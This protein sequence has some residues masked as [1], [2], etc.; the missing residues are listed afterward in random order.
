[1]QAIAM[2]VQH[3]PYLKM[4]LTERVN[5]RR[6]RRQRMWVTPPIVV[7]KPAPVYYV[8][9]RPAK[10]IVYRMWFEDLIL[11]AEQS[12]HKPILRIEHVQ[13][14]CARF[15]GITREDILNICRKKHFV[16]PRQVA[17]Y[18]AKKITL[19]SFPEIGRRFGGRDHSTVLHAVNK[20]GRLIAEDIDIASQVN[21]I[22]A[23]IAMRFA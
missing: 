8:R 14:E 13:A 22:R 1:M 10:S 15:Y 11:A 7:P 2:L 20:V 5:A 9:K 16:R 23:A 4:P 21:T 17:M 12:Y 18:L 19:Q 3:D 6:L